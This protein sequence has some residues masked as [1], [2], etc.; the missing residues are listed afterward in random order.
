MDWKTGKIPRFDW[1]SL[2]FPSCKRCND[3]YSRLENQVKELVIRLVAREP[4]KV[5]QYLPVL[6]WFDKVRIGLWLGYR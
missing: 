3:K 5:V 1:S 2:V 4:I 6:D